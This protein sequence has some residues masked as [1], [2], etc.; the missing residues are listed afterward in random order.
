[1]S[2]VH[3][4]QTKNPRPAKDLA[5]A[6]EALL[7]FRNAG[8]V[9]K[10]DDNFVFSLISQFDEKGYLTGPQQK[11]VFKLMHKF[12]GIEETPVTLANTGGISYDK[13]FDMFDKAGM[14]LK[15]PK[16][17]FKV[18]GL[19]LKLYPGK[20]TD[21]INVCTQNPYKSIGWIKRGSAQFNRSKYYK[22][23]EA[24]I[25]LILPFMELLA[26]N[27]ESTAVR[28][29][30]LANSCCYCNL[31]LTDPKSV[32]AGYGPKCAENYG[33]PWGNK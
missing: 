7:V 28:Y 18:N 6:V 20:A 16:M 22:D 8:M 24:F 21:S 23:N 26:K 4:I 1:M 9:P 31:T 3:E 10:A 25:G 29:G 5:E 11:W 17:F 19:N 14:K 27:P 30:K 32:T 13:L 2:T 15:K 12:M 33:L